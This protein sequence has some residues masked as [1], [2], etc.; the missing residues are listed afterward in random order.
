[1]DVDADV[2]L[3]KH[4]QGLATSQPDPAEQVS[5][6]QPQPVEVAERLCS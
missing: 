3:R 2:G 1:M 4:E 6:P 5:V